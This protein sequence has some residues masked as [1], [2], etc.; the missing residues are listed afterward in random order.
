MFS[1]HSRAFVCM[2]AGSATVCTR[3]A[4]HD[5]VRQNSSMDGLK[6][7]MSPPLAAGLLYPMASEGEEVRLLQG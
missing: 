7:L 1:R 5:Q 3:P 4:A 6:G 2:S